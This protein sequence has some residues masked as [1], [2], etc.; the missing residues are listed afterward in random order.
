M[1]HKKRRAV[2]F[3]RPVFFVFF[4][5]VVFF[6]I[7]NSLPLHPALHAEAFGHKPLRQDIE[8]NGRQC[9]Q[10]GERCQSAVIHHAV[11]TEE[12]VEFQRH[13]EL[14]RR[15][16]QYVRYEEISPIAGKGKDGH[17]TNPWYHQR[18][19][20]FA[21]SRKYRGTIYPRCFFQVSW[22]GIPFPHL[23]FISLGSQI[24]KKAFK[25]ERIK[26]TAGI[27]AKSLHY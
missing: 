18:C 12:L 26:I 27:F 14:F 17:R 4:C 6:R 23:I 22:N 1:Q 11:L 21:D 5:F 2:F 7:A 13:R 10:H 3:T 24:F 25:L 15:L 20:D 19:N 8:H 9:I 16:Q